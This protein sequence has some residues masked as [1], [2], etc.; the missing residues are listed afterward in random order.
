MIIKK[1]HYRGDVP[2]H[3]KR[4]AEWLVGKLI[5]EAFCHA[6]NIQ[7]LYKICL[8]SFSGKNGW[9]GP[10]DHSDNWRVTLEC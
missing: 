1:V 2:D 3:I 9:L 10:W 4:F 8:C 5:N 7:I 6:K